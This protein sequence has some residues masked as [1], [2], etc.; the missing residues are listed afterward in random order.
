MYDRDVPT[1]DTDAL[2]AGIRE[3]LAAVP[4]VAAAYLFGSVAR[5]TPRDDSDLDIGVVYPRGVRSH[6][7]IAPTLASAL[8]RATGFEHVDVV[9]LAAQ[10]SIFAHRV[11][12][13]GRL[14][15]EA[16]RE[17]RIDFESDTMR[18]A[19]DFMPTYRIAT[20][21]KPAALRRWLRER[22]GV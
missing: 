6:E 21:G 18:Y 14:V 11:L 16:D 15:Y 1:A 22:Y 19:F 10:G 9:D 20:A 17:R 4:E 13:D 7:R 3:V 2:V 5:G 8:A 12:C